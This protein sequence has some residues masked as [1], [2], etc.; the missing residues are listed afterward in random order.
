MTIAAVR[1]EGVKPLNIFSR[2][3]LAEAA[4]SDKKG[5]KEFFHEISPNLAVI[6]GLGLM[7]DVFWM[8]WHL[9]EVQIVQAL[10]TINIY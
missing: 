2:R 10:R 7:Y 1:K 9:Q 4:C 8:F 3:G 5:G 6:F